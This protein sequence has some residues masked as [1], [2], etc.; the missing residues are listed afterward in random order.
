MVVEGLLEVR[1]RLILRQLLFPGGLL[2][3]APPGQT[4]R[5]SSS[6][7]WTSTSEETS[8][9]RWSTQVVRGRSPLVPGERR[10][11][12]TTPDTENETKPL[13]LYIRSEFGPISQRRCRDR[14]FTRIL[15][16]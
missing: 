9:S 11:R 3:S 13:P 8:P 15:T 12:T 1:R 7:G 6:W 10:S 4:T 2:C 5:S 14:D 16:P